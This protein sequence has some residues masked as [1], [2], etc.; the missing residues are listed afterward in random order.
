MPIPLISWAGTS[1]DR[2]ATQAFSD[3]GIQYFVSFS[4]PDLA[5]RVAAVVAGL[6]VM[7]LSGTR[8]TNEVEIA[9]DAHLP[10]LPVMRK[11]IYLGQ[12]VDLAG[13]DPVARA[14]ASCVKRPSSS[15]VISA[16]TGRRASQGTSSRRA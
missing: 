5:S 7:I 8:L 11:G 3:A 12:S 1:S 6:G 9:N 14:L 13:V 15:N 16:K 4:A 10:T 2:H